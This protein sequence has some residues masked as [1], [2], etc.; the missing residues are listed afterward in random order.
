MA[1]RGAEALRH[2][3]SGS[4]AIDERRISLDF[5]HGVHVDA[6][7]ILGEG[8]FHGRSGVNDMAGDGPV[9]GPLAL[10]DEQLQRRV[11]A[12]ASDHGVLACVA[13]SDGRFCKRPCAAIDAASA[14]CRA[15]ARCGE[16]CPR[17][18]RAC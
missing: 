16:H 7:D 12:C 15:C 13:F 6:L 2:I 11:P 4:A 9:L 14:S 18:R 8:R 5:V 1:N 3:F 10:A 17:S